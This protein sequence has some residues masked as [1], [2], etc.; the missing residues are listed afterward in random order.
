MTNNTDTQNE[1]DDTQSD[2]DT[3]QEQCNKNE[4]SAADFENVSIDGA[5][6]IDENDTTDTEN[7][8][9]DE[10]HGSESNSSDEGVD[11][12]EN[13]HGENNSNDDGNEI[14]VESF[15]DVDIDG[16][17]VEEDDESTCSDETGS[18]STDGRNDS[19]KGDEDGFRNTEAANNWNGGDDKSVGRTIKQSGGN[20]VERHGIDIGVGDE[21]SNHDSSSKSE[22]QGN[23]S[24]KNEDDSND[25]PT[26]IN[27]EID[28][29][30]NDI[31]RTAGHGGA[32]TDSNKGSKSRSERLFG[33]DESTL[34]T[35]E[36]ETKSDDQRV[37]QENDESQVRGEIEREHNSTENT[38]TTQN[39]IGI[40]EP[41]STID[42]S[43][44]VPPEGVGEH[45]LSSPIALVSESIITVVRYVLTVVGLFV[46]V[47][48]W[49]VKWIGK[50]FELLGTILLVYYVSMVGLGVIW[51][52]PA[53]ILTGTGTTVT[54]IG[55]I[56]EVT[57]IVLPSAV[58]LLFIGVM[59]D[60]ILSDG[61]RFTKRERFERL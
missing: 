53:G 32:G 51:P 10:S 43:S 3:Q 47:I 24:D 17:T 61:N 16:A 25:L 27:D 46:G 15:T 45:Q 2:E 6:G 31:E 38:V 30:N 22:E 18:D 42:P 12:K 50:A 41:S 11:R 55:V 36:T 28:E 58:I 59:I 21:N 60:K 54:R 8:D 34:D 23:E 29:V 52:E 26:G 5:K 20:D 44:A 14:T 40:N 35:N 9:D 56:Q 13:E 49:V 4:L 48:Q 33:S 39:Q 7:T 57:M 37:V 1:T 19:D